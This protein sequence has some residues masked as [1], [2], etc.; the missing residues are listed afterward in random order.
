MQVEFDLCRGLSRSQDHRSRTGGKTIPLGRSP[1]AWTSPRPE[2]AYS[3]GS[4]NP[5]GCLARTWHAPGT[6]ACST[7]SLCPGMRSMDVLAVS[8]RSSVIKLPHA[9]TSR[10]S[11]VRDSWVRAE[12]KLS[13]GFPTRF[14]QNEP[15][16]R[17]GK[18]TSV[19]NLEAGR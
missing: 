17:I 2:S 13:G 11:S 16:S 12:R 19:P 3:A 1:R 4:M 8:A 10:W 9:F 18:L 15:Q 14:F 7:F 5:T 6:N